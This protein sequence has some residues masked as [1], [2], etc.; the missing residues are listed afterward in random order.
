M[1]IYHQIKKTM[2][3]TQHMTYLTAQ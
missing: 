1:M 2:N 3:A